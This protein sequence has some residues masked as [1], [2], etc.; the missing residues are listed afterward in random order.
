MRTELC[1]F[2]FLL[3]Y[4]KRGFTSTNIFYPK[5][6]FSLQINPALDGQKEKLQGRLLAIIFYCKN[7]TGSNYFLFLKFAGRRDCKWQIII[8]IFAHNTFV[9]EQKKIVMDCET[10]QHDYL[11]G[12]IFAGI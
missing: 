6:I 7:M 8:Q 4:C 3:I 2:V 12:Q 10:Q 5:E 1:Y 11:G 9:E